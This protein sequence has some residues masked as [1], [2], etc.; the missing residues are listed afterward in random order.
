MAPSLRWSCSKVAWCSCRDSGHRAV[1]PLSLLGPPIKG[2]KGGVGAHLV[3][4]DQGAGIECSGHPHP[5]GGPPP[6]VSFQRPHSPFFRL[7]PIRFISLLRVGSLRL[8]PA[9]L[10]RKRR[11]SWTVAAGLARTSSSSSFLVASS[12]MGGLPPPFLGVR[13]SPRSA[14]LV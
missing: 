4:E 7:N 8:L 3:H 6:L 5:P 10:L 1:G 12:A 14:S 11:R 13:G 2:R 9:K